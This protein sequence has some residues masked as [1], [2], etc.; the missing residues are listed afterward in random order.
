MRCTSFLLATVVVSENI[1]VENDDSS[2]LL[3]KRKRLKHM[4]ADEPKIC[5]AI[6]DPHY[7]TFDGQEIKAHCYGPLADYHILKSDTLSVQGRYKGRLSHDHEDTPGIATIQGL[8]I[9][10]SLVDN[11]YISI[12]PMTKLNHKQWAGGHNTSLEGPTVIKADGTQLTAKDLTC[13][14]YVRWRRKKCVDPNTKGALVDKWFKE[15]TMWDANTD[16]IIDAVDTLTRKEVVTNYL[17]WRDYTCSKEKYAEVCPKTIEFDSFTLRHGTGPLSKVMK[18]PCEGDLTEK[19][20]H[21][22]EVCGACACHDNVWIIDI[23]GVAVI[24]INQGARQNIAIKV[25]DREALGGEVGGHCGNFN[26]DADDDK[27][28]KWACPD[29][30]D[31][32]PVITGEKPPL[33]EQLEVVPPLVV[34]QGENDEQGVTVERPECPFA[35]QFEKYCGETQGSDMDLQAIC[36]LDC[37]NQFAAPNRG[38]EVCGVDRVIDDPPELV[39]EPPVPCANHPPAQRKAVELMCQEE[40]EASHIFGDAGTNALHSCMFDCC[41]D[42]TACPDRGDGGL[43]SDCAVSKSGMKSFDAESEDRLVSFKH[44]D[45]WL[46]KSDALSIQGRFSSSDPDTI[47]RPSLVGVAITGWLLGDPHTPTEEADIDVEEYP[48]IEVGAGGTVVIDGVAHTDTV[49]TNCYDVYFGSQPSVQDTMSPEFAVLLQQMEDVPNS[50]L[51]V[52]K[53]CIGQN[54]ELAGIT[55][56]NYEDGT[57][58]LLI[59]ADTILTDSTGPYSAELSG[60]CGNADG[61]LSNDNPEDDSKQELPESESLFS[62]DHPTAGKGCTDSHFLVAA[63]TK[64]PYQHEARLWRIEGMTENE[65][66]LECASHKTCDYFSWAPDGEFKELCMGCKAH[67]GS[68]HD[69][70]NFYQV[71]KR[72]IK[73]PPQVAPCINGYRFIKSDTKCN[74]QSAN[75]LWRLEDE[76]EES[77]YK[78]CASDS[79]CMFFSLGG[80]SSSHPGICMGCDMQTQGERHVGFSYYQV[81][82]WLPD[83][84]KCHKHVHHQCHKDNTIYPAKPADSWQECKAACVDRNSGAHADCQWFAYDPESKSCQI[85]RD[86]FVFQGMGWKSKWT[87]FALYCPDDTVDDAFQEL[88]SSPPVDEE[89]VVRPPVIPTFPDADVPVSPLEVDTPRLPPDE[90]LEFDKTVTSSCSWKKAGKLKMLKD[91]TGKDMFEFKGGVKDPYVD[92][93]YD[94]SVYGDGP[95]WRTFSTARE[96]NGWTGACVAYVQSKGETCDTWCQRTQNMTCV[97]GMDD[98]HHQTSKLSKWMKDEGGY[99]MEEKHGGCT[100]LPSGHTRKG[101]LE[102]KGCDQRWQT[103]IC[104]CN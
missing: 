101:S 14:G 43:F 12:P 97:R 84:N 68:H 36:V 67:E 11:A 102:N 85:C 98:A 23:K 39:V 59:Q 35:E 17:A 100:I 13:D 88:D 51:V 78:E 99:E 20:K 42:R 64:C 104:A 63:N 76:T 72:A 47:P 79:E 83:S 74:Y 89:L 57:Q 32:P 24:N 1:A 65:C 71:C 7:S 16:E 55:I 52:L 31:P 73:P 91:C 3:Q 81:C 49:T 6:G 95:K 44:S 94:P 27:F 93:S 56:N 58:E 48:V 75:R 15:Q 62:T 80:K 38:Q 19:Q 90:Q 5:T 87:T 77:C 18:Y 29:M 4:K 28:D 86:G 92:P 60:F 8:L 46:L 40:L 61:D 10:G 69:G 70:F 30:I 103:Q 53:S 2:G 22:L 37:C 21:D 66:Y 26:G 50:V 9:T 82:D 25:L 34:C 33:L 45:Y 41:D 54:E 96:E